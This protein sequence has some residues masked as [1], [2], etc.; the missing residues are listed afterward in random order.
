VRERIQQQCSATVGRNEQ[1]RKHRSRGELTEAAGFLQI[2]NLFA[3]HRIVGLQRAELLVEHDFIVG[4]LL[5]GCHK[6]GTQFFRSRKTA[7]ISEK[8][9]TSGITEGG[10]AP[11]MSVPQARQRQ[12]RKARI[13]VEPWNLHDMVAALC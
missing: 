4:R 8:S 7:R 3:E 11:A 10:D 13:Q 9:S 1:H 12:N 2:M 5:V 6:E